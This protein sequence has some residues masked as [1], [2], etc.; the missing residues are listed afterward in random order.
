MAV[1]KSR[2]NFIIASSSLLA[3][4]C[5]S[6]DRLIFEPEQQ[7]LS[8]VVVIGGGLAGLTAALELKKRGISYTLF[9]A[10]SRLGGR[11]LT[12]RE[13]NSRGEFVSTDLGLSSI[14]DSDT[15]LFELLKEFKIPMTSFSEKSSGK[16]SEK[17]SERVELRPK[18]GFT[19]LIEALQNR[20]AGVPEGRFLK[21]S[22]QVQSISLETNKLSVSYLKGQLFETR[23]C[24]RVIVAVPPSK[25]KSI[26]TPMQS[27]FAREVVGF[28]ES[29]KMEVDSREGIF[30]KNIPHIEGGRSLRGVTQIIPHRDFFHFSQGPIE[31][32]VVGDYTSQKFFGRGAGAVESAQ[33]AVRRLI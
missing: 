29:I 7:S 20:V 27:P 33:D 12:K 8:E 18:E 26:F 10:S 13:L 14:W 11:V 9:E 3:A 6:I 16:S 5:S 23:K 24:S 19:R 22:A 21:I 25:L 31:I 1:D 15:P 30:W 4:G 28:S 17:S 2:R 32:A